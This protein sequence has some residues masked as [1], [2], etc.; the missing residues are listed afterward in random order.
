MNNTPSRLK[1]PSA[2]SSTAAKTTPKIQ[3]G[4]KP[5]TSAGSSSRPTV[6]GADKTASLRAAASEKVKAF[7]REEKAAKEEKV[8][9]EKK[10]SAVPSSSRVPGPRQSLSGT[11]GTAR[12]LPTSTALGRTG[13][14]VLRGGKSVAAL[15]LSADSS[16]LARA[17][18]LESASRSHSPALDVSSNSSF[19][20]EPA[21]RGASHD[22]PWQPHQL[23]CIISIGIGCIQPRQPRR[24][25]HHCLP[26][27]HHNSIRSTKLPPRTTRHAVPLL[28]AASRRSGPAAPPPPT[29]PT[30][31]SPHAA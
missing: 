5:A 14:P 21:A 30:P 29:K 15:R 3:S 24:P 27:P 16:T 2:S 18:G 22:R 26:R 17:E 12:A 23:K 13:I 11:T 1:P 31:T 7:E 10:P 9:Q 20:S 6:P 8:G 4:D 28:R 19:L 25:S